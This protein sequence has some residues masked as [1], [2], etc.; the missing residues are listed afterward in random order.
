MPNPFTRLARAFAGA[1]ALLALG[2]G[3]SPAEPPAPK[4]AL[5]GYEAFEFVTMDV[6]GVTVHVQ[7]HLAEHQKEFA[8]IL[9]DYLAEEAKLF[10]EADTLAPRAGEIVTEILRLVGL[11]ADEKLAADCREAFRFYLHAWRIALPGRK[12][13][14]YL[15][16]RQ[17]VKDHLRKGGKLSCF[18]YD[19]AADE[20]TYKARWGRQSE[21][22]EW[23]QALAFPIPLAE[24]A[25]EATLRDCL[26]GVRDMLKENT[27]GAAMHEVIETGIAFKRLRPADPHFRWFSDG[28]ANALTIHLLEKYCGRE[29]SEAFAKGFDPAGVK[30]PRDEVNLRYW[31]GIMGIELD[32]PDER[33]LWQ[34]RYDYATLEARRLIDAHGV[35]IVALEG[36]GQVPLRRGAILRRQLLGALLE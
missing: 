16:G 20:A 22:P 23:D 8:K 17:A 25:P 35:D 31:P 9:D 27:A 33:D 24:A 32:D 36:H 6:R 5:E 3:A 18:S 4:T 14:V 29:T 12:V 30:C 15:V 19:K 21:R 1:L 10:V 13:T 26:A 7:K 34:A 11:Q 2:A 28:F